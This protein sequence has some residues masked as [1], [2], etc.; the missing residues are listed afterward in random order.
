MPSS[1]RA[2][3]EWTPSR[4]VHWA[5]KTGLGTARVVSEI[6]ASRPHPEQGFRSC[7]GVMRLGEIHGAARLEAACLRAEHLGS[8]RYKT[9]K[10]ILT[11]G[12]EQLALEEEVS[13]RPGPVVHDN[14]RGSEYYK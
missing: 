9:V 2:H 6:L 7:M 5:E 1:H 13:Q 11:S 14:I 3:A 8:Y 4:L 10:N 12:L